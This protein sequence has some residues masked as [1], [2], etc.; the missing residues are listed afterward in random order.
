VRY[1]RII[2][3]I[4]IAALAVVFLALSYKNSA[5][6]E[7]VSIH[8]KDGV[9][10]RRDPTVLGLGREHSLPDYR[11]K[12]HVSRRLLSVD[13][14]TRLNTSATNWI[15]FP[16]KDMVP[17]RQLKEILI[18]EDDKVA[19]DLLDRIAVSGP[20]ATGTSFQC[21]LTAGRSF[22]MGMRWFFETPVGR[23]IFIASILLMVSLPATLLR[24]PKQ[25]PSQ[26]PPK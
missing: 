4:A 22:D 19:N 5:V 13:L 12:L 23:A 21:R 26:P 11:V 20:E 8:L 17:L 6:V 16:V 24:G 1:V 3:A 14:G 25:Q 18:I 9:T 15:E 10:E 7:A 2:I